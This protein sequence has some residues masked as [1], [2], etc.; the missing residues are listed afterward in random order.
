M[1]KERRANLKDLFKSEKLVPN[2]VEEE[3]ADALLELS[4]SGLFSIGI[5]YEWRIKRPNRHRVKEEGNR[6]RKE[7]C[8]S[9]T[10]PRRAP[11]FILIFHFYFIGFGGLPLGLF[12]RPTKPTLSQNSKNSNAYIEVSCVC[13]GCCLGF[14]LSDLNN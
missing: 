9:N 6:R 7:D 4:C 5:G 2:P 11:T 3:G 10:R 13:A 8:N 1:S 12:K 14:G